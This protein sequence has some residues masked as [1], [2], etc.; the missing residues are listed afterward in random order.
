[1]LSEH[2][3]LSISWS[4]YREITISPSGVIIKGTMIKLEGL[5]T[6]EVK[7][8]NLKLEGQAV[9]E[10]KGTMLTLQG[11]AMTQIKGGIINIG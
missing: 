9:T 1:A 6:T 11:S 3:T 5:S 8:I 7:G 2:K 10:M 4:H